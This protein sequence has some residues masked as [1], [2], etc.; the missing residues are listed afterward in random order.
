MVKKIKRKG[1]TFRF[2]DEEMMRETE[3]Y[4]DLFH[5]EDLTPATPCQIRSMILCL[6]NKR[7]SKEPRKERNI[8][9]TENGIEQ[10]ELSA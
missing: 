10:I 9:I 5:F 1:A 6:C 3:L 7:G 4:R 2:Q 8:I